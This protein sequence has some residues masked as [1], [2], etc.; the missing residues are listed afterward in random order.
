M[1][2]EA[3]PAGMGTFIALTWR[4]T[5]HAMRRAPLVF[6]GCFVAMAAIGVGFGFLD[7]V[8]EKL[9]ASS[10]VLR[11]AGGAAQIAA[12][13]LKSVLISLALAP[14]AVVVH[15]LVILDDKA[16][17]GHVRPY[18][19]WLFG[20]LLFWKAVQLPTLLFGD[21]SFAL[22]WLATGIVGAVLLRSALLFPALA[23][24][25]PANSIKARVEESW[26]LATGHLRRLF[27]VWGGAALPLIIAL[28]VLSRRSG[29]TEGAAAPKPGAAMVIAVL[30]AALTLVAVAISAAAASWVYLW[31]LDHPS[32]PSK[33]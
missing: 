25:V 15:R 18:A 31:A 20:F 26:R 5:A 2:T 8:I 11:Q 32:E 7:G 22:G 3:K 10:W 1:V 12:A 30:G 33:S 28:V 17:I 27:V 16:A 29:V 23:T 19:G 21:G 9:P 24:D 4:S 6:A 14:V 13:V